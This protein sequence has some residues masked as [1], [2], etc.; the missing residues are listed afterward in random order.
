[1]ASALGFMIFYQK[2]CKFH[3]DPE[4]C[5][6]ESLVLSGDL[7]RSCDSDRDRASRTVGLGPS[8]CQPV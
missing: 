4:N 3:F 2:N 5:L 1:M 7:G 8:W 6:V